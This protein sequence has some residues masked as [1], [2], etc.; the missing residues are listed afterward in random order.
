M[1][2]DK[3]ELP[4]GP[5]AIEQAATLLVQKIAR[6]RGLP[7]EA[8]DDLQQAVS[9]KLLALTEERLQGIENLKAYL[10]TVVHNEANRLAS[11]N[12]RSEVPLDD[13]DHS[14]DFEYQRRI[15]A[16]IILREIWQKLDSEE[17]ELFRLMLFDYDE[18]EMAVR[19]KINHDAA[20]KR[21]WRFRK[22]LEELLQQHSDI[23]SRPKRPK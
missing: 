12:A 3:P 8:V 13:I 2:S 18:K 10:A 6:E 20:R 1:N 22:K 14:D 11:R 9:M 17:R 19:L 21:V 7:D 16:W 23:V 15:E 5:Q 4:L